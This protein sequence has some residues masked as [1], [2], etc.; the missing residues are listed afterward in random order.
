MKA[1]VALFTCA[2]SRAVH[3]ELVP[4]LEAS[5]FLC[6]LRRFIGR[7]G[8]P[9][10]IVSDNTKTFEAKEKSLVLLFDFPDVQ[11]HLSSKGISWQY[12]LAKAPW[13]DGFFE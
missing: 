10:L 8:L 5:T 11:E 12:N 1:Y 3:L 7:R 2:T 13:W 6:S 9:R 4:N